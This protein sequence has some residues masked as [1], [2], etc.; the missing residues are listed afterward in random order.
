MEPEKTIEQT[1]K[2]I[3]NPEVAKFQLMQE[4]GDKLDSLHQG[5]Q[6]IVK[7]IKEI[8][9]PEKVQIPEFPTTDLSQTNSLLEQLITSSK[10]PCQIRLT[11]TLK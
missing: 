7:A 1:T 5:I 6:E 8:P 9:Q 3:R 4:H 2:F 11:L 10:E